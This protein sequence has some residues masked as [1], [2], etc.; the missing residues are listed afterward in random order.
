MVE[1]CAH[2]LHAD[3]GEPLHKLGDPYPVFQVF[4][5]SGDGDARAAKYPGAAR[6][7]RVLFNS[8]ACTLV[9]HDYTLLRKRWGGKWRK[10]MT[11]TVNH[12]PKMEVMK[13]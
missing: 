3:A 1:N 10:H 6:D 2:L 7:A 11:L 5:K 8:L 12:A 13:S 4:K 9:Q